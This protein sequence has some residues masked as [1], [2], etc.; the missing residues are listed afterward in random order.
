[1]ISISKPKSLKYYKGP[2]EL[3]ASSPGPK[4]GPGS[5]EIAE[6]PQS[7][8][9]AEQSA[10]FSAE[11][12]PAPE[13]SEVEF[14][15]TFSCAGSVSANFLHD[16]FDGVHPGTGEPLSGLR[17]NGG[18]GGAID[19]QLSMPKSCSIAA[20]L[21]PAAE[22]WFEKIID[23]QREA[24]QR[25]MQFALDSGLFA[26]RRSGEYQP[27]KAVASTSFTHVTSR[28][29]D[30]QIHSHCLAFMTALRQDSRLCQIDGY[31]LKL[32]QPVLSA[33]A[34][35]YEIDA[36]KK[37]GL[38]IEA[39][40][41]SYCIAGIPKKLCENFSKRRV[42]IEKK[43]ESRGLKSSENRAMAQQVAYSTRA[44]KAEDEDLAIL[45]HRWHEEA[46]ALGWT[47]GLLKA[48]V[49]DQ[50]AHEQLPGRALEEVV[51][52][53]IDELVA[54]KSTFNRPEL[55]RCVLGRT[56]YYP[57]DPRRV[58]EFLFSDRSGID[59]VNTPGTVP[60]YTHVSVRAAE[61]Q[62]LRLAMNSRGKAWAARSEAV[63][64]AL[65]ATKLPGSTAAFTLTSEQQAAVRHAALGADGLTLINGT[66]GTGKSVTMR[67]VRQIFED[68]GRRVFGAALSWK[69]ATELQQSAG[70]MP[71]NCFSVEKLLY[72]LRSG[73]LTLQRGDVIILDEAGMV[74][75]F[76]FAE[77]LNFTKDVGCKLI[78]L[79]DVAQFKPV[80][81]GAPLEMLSR[82]LPMSRIEKIQ[83][84][85]GR[86]AQEASEMR[87][88]TACFAGGAVTAGL[89]YYE[90]TGALRYHKNRDAT[91]SAATEAYL[92]HMRD[93]P[94][95]TRAIQYRFFGVRVEVLALEDRA[96]VIF[97]RTQ[98]CLGVRGAEGRSCVFHVEF[99]FL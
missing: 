93:Y 3:E 8:P 54:T 62:L 40:G 1:M 16:L 35:S 67:V 88:A 84:Q 73:R 97:Q 20:A 74:G 90:S 42:E 15:N 30:M 92:E 23:I 87:R 24:S 63:G 57:F 26:T 91:I 95:E 99:P 58:I 48:A 94:D 22:G 44:D 51:K 19:I 12:N 83:R 39:D 5:R 49:L 80:A 85:I 68:E 56:Q 14:F 75:T 6:H 66:A 61:Q 52:A 78:A 82:I 50:T 18:R 46:A 38:G 41:E 60:V 89:K 47:P 33:I 25:A 70:L 65:V 9:W 28:A 71:G 72:Q 32:Y 31:L 96:G 86:N 13:N 7:S 76:H 37:L 64:L 69:A 11:E 17:K 53:A 98:C 55:L 43:L 77:L 45:R 21:L 10:L 2:R 59:I 27:V 34:R 29:G 81:A 4:P 36:L 79:G